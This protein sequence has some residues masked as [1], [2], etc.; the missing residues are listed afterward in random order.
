[1]FD[2]IRARILATTGIIVVVSLCV[3]TLINYRIANDANNE[4]IQHTLSSLTASHTATVQQ[5][6]ENQR[7]LIASL[8]PHVS[9]SDPRPLL[10]QIANAGGFIS[11]DIGYANKVE[12]SSDPSSV[13]AGFDP[14]TRAWFNNARKAG[15]PIVTAPYMDAN[16]HTLVVTLTGKSRCGRRCRGGGCPH[17]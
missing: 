10:K 14:T 7:A 17:G 11:V 5:W 16:T 9:D 12:L 13:P 3:N 15:R 1:M 6:V 2:S 4:A 8:T